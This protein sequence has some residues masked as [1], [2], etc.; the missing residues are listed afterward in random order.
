MK[1]I[2]INQCGRK[3]SKKS[4][5]VAYK[6]KKEKHGLSEIK[7][8]VSYL[9]MAMT[10]VCNGMAWVPDSTS[11][12]IPAVGLIMYPQD[13]SLKAFRSIINPNALISPSSHLSHSSYKRHNLFALKHATRLAVFDLLPLPQAFQILSTF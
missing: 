11:T 8:I 4:T 13:N 9:H 6:S 3:A 1:L 12:T 10:M 2:S 7:T 5:T